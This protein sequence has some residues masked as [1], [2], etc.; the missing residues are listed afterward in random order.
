MIPVMVP[1]AVAV[2]TSGCLTDSS[3][4]TQDENIF[5]CDPPGF[6]KHQRLPKNP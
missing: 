2:S 3:G 1:I 4:A 6:S 5:H